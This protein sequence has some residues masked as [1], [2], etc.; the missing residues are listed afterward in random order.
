MSRKLRVLLVEDSITCAAHL[1]S[2]L[3]RAPHFADVRVERTIQTAREWLAS[4]ARE[5]LVLAV[6]D[7][8][9]PD[10]RGVELLPLLS[11]VRVLIVTASPELVPPSRV[12][13][14]E[15]GAGWAARVERVFVEVSR[16]PR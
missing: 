13:T 3:R 9:L 6:L 1:A 8:E 5:D 2:R 16:K 4:S 10:G 15:K 12:E 14:V 11:S 7:V